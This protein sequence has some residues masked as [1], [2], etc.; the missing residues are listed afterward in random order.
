MFSRGGTGGVRTPKSDDRAGIALIYG[1]TYGTTMASSPRPRT[2][3]PVGIL[4]EPIEEAVRTPVK[5]PPA[6]VVSAMRVA[7]GDDKAVI[8][9]TCE[10][11]LLPAVSP[12]K[13]NQQPSLQHAQGR[14]AGISPAR[15]ALRTQ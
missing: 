3:Q 6:D 8:I 10:P 13:T 5:L 15:A 12:I 9:Y 2:V 11:T 14:R 7:T 4:P 1:T